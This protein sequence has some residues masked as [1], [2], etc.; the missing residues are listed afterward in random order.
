MSAFVVPKDYDLLIHPDLTPGDENGG[1][2]GNVVITLDIKE[3][4]DTITLHSHELTIENVTFTSPDKDQ[5][6]VLVGK[7]VFSELQVIV[8]VT[9]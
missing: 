6:L 9:F 4:T 3:P 7:S 8:L 5:S 2:K 1:F